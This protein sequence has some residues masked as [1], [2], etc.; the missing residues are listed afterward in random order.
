MR[1]VFK[2]TT[3]NKMDFFGK[4]AKVDIYTDEKAANAAYLQA[5]KAGKIGNLRK[6]TI[7][8]GTD[9]EIYNELIA[10]L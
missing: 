4:F 3:A 1:I 10:I 9:E 8:E 2:L 6:L 5:L 7:N